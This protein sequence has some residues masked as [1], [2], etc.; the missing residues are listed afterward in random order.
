M[1]LV[2]PVITDD[3]LA[4]PA[5]NMVVTLLA[6][7]KLRVGEVPSDE[8][9][10]SIINTAGFFSSLA[11]TTKDH[12]S[13]WTTSYLCVLRAKPDLGFFRRL[14]GELWDL[15]SE[16]DSHSA[17]LISI[18]PLQEAV[19]EVLEAVN[20]CRSLAAQQT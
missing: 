2:R 6:L 19:L 11:A 10:T 14:S 15:S 13:P 7:E 17:T 5:W 3:P 18:P 4:G 16:R 8:E 12:F 20:R 9:W 1:T